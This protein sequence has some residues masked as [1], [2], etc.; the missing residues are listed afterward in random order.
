MDSRSKNIG[1]GCH[2]PLQGIFP[3]LKPA[4]LTS[5]ALAGRF[6][7]IRTTW[8]VHSLVGRELLHFLKEFSS[9]TTHVMSATLMLS[10][11]CTLCSFKPLSC[12]CGSDGKE[13][14][15]NAG[16]PGSILGQEDLLEK[17]MNGN[18]L[19]YS[20]LENSMDRGAWW[21]TVHGVTK[22][23]TRLVVFKQRSVC[24]SWFN[25]SLSLLD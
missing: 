5:P 22:S 14:A 15:C 13:L 17:G 1:V 23:Q 9:L 2:A 8:E 3:G 11:L 7:T 12:S 19:Q 25:I 6:F 24:V 21:A 18:P 10:S 4:S 16:D 20:C